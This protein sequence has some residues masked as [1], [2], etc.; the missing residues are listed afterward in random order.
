MDVYRLQMETGWSSR[1]GEFLEHLCN[2]KKVFY[3]AGPG[4]TSLNANRSSLTFMPEAAGRIASKSWH[5][6][7]ID[8]QTHLA[9]HFE[10][11]T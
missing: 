1:D 4:L 7:L 9:E 11:I 2:F 6:A 5:V 8:R 10:D 3:L